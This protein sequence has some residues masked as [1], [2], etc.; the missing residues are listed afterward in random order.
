ME[1]SKY[2]RVASVS[3]VEENEGL[4]VPIDG[5]LIAVFNTGGC[6]YAIDDTC[7]HAQASL[8]DGYIEDGCVECPLHGGR[9][10]LTTGHA[11]SPPVTED[12]TTYPVQVHDGN[13]YIKVD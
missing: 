13:I 3:D 4:Q 10:E 12:V 5:R 11:V 8:A 7:T 6:F 2:Q 1:P 9:F